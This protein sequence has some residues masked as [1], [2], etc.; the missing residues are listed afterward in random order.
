MPS[1]SN[2]LRFSGRI[3]LIDITLI[4]ETEPFPKIEMSFV[5]LPELLNLGT[6]SWVFYDINIAYLSHLYKREPSSEP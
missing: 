5:H 4:M 2:R 1:R 3:Y 6:I